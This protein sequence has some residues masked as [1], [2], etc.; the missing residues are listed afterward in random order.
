MAGAGALAQ[1]AA[2]LEQALTDNDAD[3]DPQSVAALQA[4]FVTY[5]AELSAHGLAA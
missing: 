2:Q 1:F 4:L 3:L 5:R